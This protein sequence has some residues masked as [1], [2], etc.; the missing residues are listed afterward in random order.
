MPEYVDMGLSVKWANYNLGASTPAGVGDYYAW[1]ETEPKTEYTWANYKWSNGSTIALTKYCTVDTMGND[2]FTD[3]LT[4]L[5]P[6]DDAVQVRKGGNWR[7]PSSEEWEEL[8]K[9]CTWTQTELNGQTG[10]IAQS[11]INGNSI[12]IPVTGFR[13][14][15]NLVL[16]YIGGYWSS[17]L[18]TGRQSCAFGMYLNLNENRVGKYSN[19]N[20]Q[21]GF[22][23]RPVLSE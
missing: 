14:G 7:M 11:K 21:D 10:F 22:L 5:L 19:S 2:G 13:S 8:R 1:G 16:E 15:K 17:S 4:T 3:G 23:I 20:R 12:F 9:N 6:E 18:N